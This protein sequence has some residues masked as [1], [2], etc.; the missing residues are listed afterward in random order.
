MF[1][2][3]EIRIITIYVLLSGINT[4]VKSDA[5]YEIAAFHYIKNLILE[6]SKIFENQHTPFVIKKR[7]EESDTWI[8]KQLKK[9]GDSTLEKAFAR[10][11]ESAHIISSDISSII[12]SINSLK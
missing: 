11:K 7:L 2:K 8:E 3:I 12:N 4:Q 9:N 10:I 1:K 6:K 5:I